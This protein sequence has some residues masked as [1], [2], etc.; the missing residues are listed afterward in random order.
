MRLANKVAI[1][2]GAGSG[3][4]RSTAYLFAK[5]GAEVVVADIDAAEH[6]PEKEFGSIALDLEARAKNAIPDVAYCTFYVTP[7]FAY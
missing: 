7:R 6:V 2:T 4:G 5:E 1:I 3:I